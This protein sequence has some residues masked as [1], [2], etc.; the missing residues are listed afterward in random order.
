MSRQRFIHPGIWR[1]AQFVRLSYLERLLFIGCFST[2]DDE[3][4]RSADPILVK[5]D[6]FPYDRIRPSAVEKMLDKIRSEGLIV[7]YV[8]GTCN[9]PV[10]QLLGW[11][12]YQ[13]PKYRKPSRFGEFSAPDP[14]RT[15]AEPAPDPGRTRSVGC[16]CDS[17]SGTRNNSGAEKRPGV[18]ASHLPIKGT[19][20]GKP[21]LVDPM[22]VVRRDLPRCFIEAAKDAGVGLYVA[23]KVAQETGC[24]DLARLLAWLRMTAADGRVGKIK[25]TPDAYW[26]A[27][28]KSG[29][30]PPQDLYDEAKHDLLME[31]DSTELADVAMRHFA[32]CLPASPAGGK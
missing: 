5:A 31:S 28:A 22:D 23:L 24:H 10:M 19:N 16:G 15:R 3:G 26:T 27:L 6:I 17:G 21:A 7:I 14:G 13:N 29:K 9:Q 1:S 8:Q 18:V 30:S 11:C 4:R 2:A 20:N 12:K 25:T 32:E